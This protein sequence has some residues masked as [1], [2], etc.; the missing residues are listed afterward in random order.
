[1]EALCWL[2]E[3]VGFGIRS[4]F[5]PALMLINYMA[6]GC[7]WAHFRIKILKVPGS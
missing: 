5:F 1:M 4:E 2:V 3:H 7:Y 6:L